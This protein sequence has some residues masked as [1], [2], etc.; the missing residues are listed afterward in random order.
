MSRVRVPSPAPFP[1]CFQSS[2]KTAQWT[3]GQWTFGLNIDSVV[4]ASVFRWCCQHKRRTKE[5]GTKTRS[6]RAGLVSARPWQ[7]RCAGSAGKPVIS[8][9]LVPRRTLRPKPRRSFRCCVRPESAAI[10]LAPGRPASSRHSVSGK[11][12]PGDRSSDFSA[13]IRRNSSGSCTYNSTG[14]TTCQ[15]PIFS[16]RSLDRERTNLDTQ[17]ARMVWFSSRWRCGVAA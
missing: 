3:F 10:R 4:R 8:R 9:Q 14:L 17:L 1:D 15:Y 2:I 6:R 7:L 16:V 11:P 12:Q 13:P 5:M